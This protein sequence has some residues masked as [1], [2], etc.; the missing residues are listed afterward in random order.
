MIL[1]LED[2]TEERILRQHLNLKYNSTSDDETMMTSLVSWTRKCCKTFCETQSRTWVEL[3]LQLQV[4]SE[5]TSSWP[6]MLNESSTILISIMASSHTNHWKIDR[7]C[8]NCGV[9]F[10]KMSKKKGER[11][12]M[13]RGQSIALI[14]KEVTDRW[15]SQARGGLKWRLTMC[16]RFF[17]RFSMKMS[18]Y[19]NSTWILS[20]LPDAKSVHHY[21][22]LESRGKKY[23]KSKQ[24][25]WFEAKPSDSLHKHFSSFFQLVWKLQAGRIK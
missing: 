5:L 4:T 13:V 7:G 1:K 22:F 12:T 18:V 25:L 10:V 6:Q 2:E 14:R 16:L 21:V 15:I 23:L 9:H 24:L 20:F 17:R 19:K 11:N 8:Q 3:L